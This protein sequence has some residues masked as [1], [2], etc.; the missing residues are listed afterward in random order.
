MTIVYSAR[1]Q[2]DCRRVLAQT[3]VAAVSG[4]TSTVCCSMEYPIALY[5]L[6]RRSYIL[7]S[8]G[9]WVGV[10]LFSKLLLLRNCPKRGSSDSGKLEPVSSL[11][12]LQRLHHGISDSH[13]Q[14]KAG[15]YSRVHSSFHWIP[16]APRRCRLQI[17]YCVA[18]AIREPI[19][20]RS[21]RCFLD[22]LAEY[23]VCLAFVRVGLHFALQ[24]QIDV[25]GGANAY[26]PLSAQGAASL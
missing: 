7:A 17:H 25:H 14:V 6:S 3:S 2:F 10:Q 26:P 9:T 18:D 5:P 16:S 12:G 21:A 8:I 4:R 22:Y 11:H 23:L 20:K 15:K 24:C 13:I 1:R 19:F